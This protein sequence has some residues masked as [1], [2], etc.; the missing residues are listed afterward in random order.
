M[1]CHFTKMWI[2]LL[3]SAGVLVAGCGQAG[4][5]TAP[6]ATTVGEPN[7]LSA[8]PFVPEP[9]V[10][11]GL[12]ATFT[13]QPVPIGE[14]PNNLGLDFANA[15]PLAY[16]ANLPDAL[17][18]TIQN[19]QMS[20]AITDNLVQRYPDLPPLSAGMGYISLQVMVTCQ[21]AADAYC[22]VNLAGAVAVVMANGEIVP[23]PNGIIST[24]GNFVLAGGTTASGGFALQAPTDQAFVLQITSA[25]GKV[26]F[27]QPSK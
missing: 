2:V 17:S 9:T 7:A 19:S 11:L 10:T 20:Q 18:L 22:T 3:L 8:T 21:K 5:G 15:I 12:P 16:T 23:Q 27:V 6:V 25:D 4:Q 26:V 1:M 24:G 13:P 14:T